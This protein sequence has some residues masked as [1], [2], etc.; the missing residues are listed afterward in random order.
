MPDIARGA[1]V[2]SMLD[3]CSR[4]AASGAWETLR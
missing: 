1:Q 2:Q 3:A 4:S